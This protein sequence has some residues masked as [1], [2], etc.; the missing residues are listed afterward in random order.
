MSWFHS[1]NEWK[2]ADYV[3]VTDGNTVLQFKQTS[4]TCRRAPRGGSDATLTSCQLPL[5]LTEEEEPRVVT[6][7]EV[8]FIHSTGS[9]S[10][11]AAHGSTLFRTHGKFHPHTNTNTNTTRC[12]VIAYIWTRRKVHKGRLCALK[13]ALC[14]LTRPP[15][16]LE[17]SS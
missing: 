12:A 13:S 9:S 5:K 3:Q 11:I 10:C 15:S 1:Y 6:H 14:F 7:P 4:K 16:E 8:M 2:Y 17:A